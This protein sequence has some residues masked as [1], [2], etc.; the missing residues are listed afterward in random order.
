MNF[1]QVLTAMVTPFSHDGE[2]DYDAT[3]K[4][5]NH[6][7]RTGTD[8]LVV[9]GTTGESPTLSLEEKVAIWRCVIDTVNGRIPVIAGTGTN[10][11][12]ESIELTKI[13]EKEGVD[14][15]MLVTPY[16]N[17]PSQQGMFEHFKAI[18]E[19]T[20]LPIML[21]NI[22]GRSVVNLEVDTIVELA[23]IDNIV[24]IKEA[25]GNL[26][27]MSEIIERT[28]DSFTLY[29]GDDALTLPVLSIGGTGI[30]SVASHIV[31][32]DMKEMIQ[33]FFNGEVKKAADIHRQLL[34]IFNSLFIAPNPTPVKE[35]L[36]MLGMSV[37]SVR[38]PLV[39]LTKNE[40]IV[41]QKSIQYIVDQ[42][43]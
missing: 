20:T 27:A 29:S 1:G 2:V 18:A 10:S 26:N 11:T 15:V 30:V 9:T 7:I 33:A 37:G 28:P 19:S 35:A 34:P 3:R 31:G 32:N 6:L 23:K 22:P 42:A 4:L 43:S 14:G 5:V 38:L 40:K 8:A 17:K 13:A 21:Y 36:A 39:P 41:L 24:S 12:K 25:S 16:Y